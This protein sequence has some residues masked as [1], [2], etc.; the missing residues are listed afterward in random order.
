MNV[1]PDDWNVVERQEPA[2][3]PRVALLFSDEQ[4]DG[5]H[6]LLIACTFGVLLSVPSEVLSF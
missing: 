1:G 3:V 6:V 2:Q 4:P 5:Q